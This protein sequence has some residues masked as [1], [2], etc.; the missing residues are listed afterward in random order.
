[1]NSKVSIRM[2]RNKDPSELGVVVGAGFAGMNISETLD[3]LGFSC[4]D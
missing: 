4:T 3:L 1:M 2:G